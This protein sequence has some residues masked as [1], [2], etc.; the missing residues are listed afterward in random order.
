MRK[1]RKKIN[2]ARLGLDGRYQ[3]RSFLKEVKGIGGINFEQRQELL[4]MRLQSTDSKIKNQGIRRVHF[5]RKDVCNETLK[6]T[7]LS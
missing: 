1:K 5:H 7:I 3:N 2:V 6:K 4:M